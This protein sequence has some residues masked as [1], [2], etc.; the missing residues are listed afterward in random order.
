MLLFVKCQHD[1]RSDSNPPVSPGHHI[2]PPEDLKALEELGE[3]QY[4]VVELGEWKP[5]NAKDKVQL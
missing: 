2:I 4:G 3:G 5:P 1:K